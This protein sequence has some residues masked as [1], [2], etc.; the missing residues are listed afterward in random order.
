METRIPFSIIPI[1]TLINVGS[2][3]MMLILDS[4]PGQR[5]GSFAPERYHNSFR[6]D[7]SITFGGSYPLLKALSGMC[8]T[9]QYCR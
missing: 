8:P 3:P 4:A 9:T 7:F 1:L 2:I 5:R 6:T